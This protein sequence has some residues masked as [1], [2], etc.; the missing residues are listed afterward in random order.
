MTNVA[1]AS[2][3]PLLVTSA[4]PYANGPAHLGHL[5]EHI[6]TDIWVRFQ[7]LI[8]REVLY[9]CAADTHGTPIEVNARKQG[10]SPALM[11]E[12]FRQ[13][14]SR[15]FAAF[16]VSHDV[17]HTTHSPENRAY[18][19]RIYEALTAKGLIYEKPLEQFYDESDA[20]FLPD[21]YVK[22]KCPKCGTAD[23]Y[24]DNCEN[25]SATYQPT[26]LV[27]PYS[28]L[29]GKPPVR[30]TSTHL[31]VALKQ[32]E[33]FLR[34]FMTRL[35][36]G[37]RN[38][39]EKWLDSGLEDWCIS[40]D[41]PYFGFEIPGTDKFFY[42]WLDAPVGYISSTAHLTA[43][44]HLDLHKWWPG[45]ADKPLT[46]DDKTNGA[47]IVHVI[48]KDIVYFHTLF[49]PAMLHAAG[50]QLPSDVHVHGMLNFGGAKMSKSRGRMITVRDWLGAG[51]DPSY[52]RY[53]LAANLG[54]ALDDIEFST[55]EFRNRVNSQLVNNVGNLSNRVLKFVAAQFDSTLS[56]ATELDPAERAQLDG[57]IAGAVE[58]Y[59][60]WNFRLA[61]QHVESLGGWANEFMQRRAPF[62]TVKT[63]PALARADVTLL[64]N[65]IKAIGT[66]LLPVVPSFA[67][68]LLDQLGVK[69]RALSEG[70][71]FDLQDHHIGTP[72]ALLPPLEPATIDALFAPKDAVVT[73]PLVASPPAE[74]A[75]AAPIEPIKDAI[76]IDDF[77]K[78]DLRVGIVVS[79]ES[80]PG[81][82][83][84]LKLT[85]DVGEGTPRT[86]A[87][88]I[89]KAYKP[90]E[91]LG[92]RVV[93]VAN[94][95]PREMKV[96]KVKLTS[97]GMLL[98]A[99][100]GPRGLT[101]ADVPESSPAGARVK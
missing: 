66:L 33:P 60:T 69:V 1:P 15:D 88:G 75:P 42:V 20:R 54:P 35:S 6:Q 30:R 53:Y 94:L 92:K 41:G 7:R 68:R 17:F 32:L 96:G 89:A 4:L 26:D 8:G 10:L 46:D 19:V 78:I 11:T 39:V 93:V 67:R 3:R 83:K 98:A 18:A 31:W 14:Q 12:R 43:N 25:C 77:G 49:W 90:E 87:A 65:V 40:R 64:A 85:V 45:T 97:Q 70:L 58:A 99:G 74:T 71:A 16:G 44:R 79:A 29:T 81:A 48:G 5:V 76:S 84:L 100:G 55:E 37:V 51:L 72:T 28:V 47:E 9:V 61:L 50:F 101:L 56:T 34:D 82:D 52:L 59:G 27:E 38:Y 24:G 36:P 73:A 95:A 80:I 57:W 91:L 21:R 13:E 23:Q 22:G 62:R 63:D 2:K 86:I